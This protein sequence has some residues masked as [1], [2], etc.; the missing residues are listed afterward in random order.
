MLAF[1]RSDLFLRFLGGFALGA[2]GMF[3]FASPDSPF[4][5]QSAVAASSYSQN[6]AL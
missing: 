2:V 6:A 3:A 4:K 1:V 5:T